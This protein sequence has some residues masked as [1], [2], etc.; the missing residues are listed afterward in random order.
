MIRDKHTV[1]QVRYE[2]MAH[3]NNRKVRGLLYQVLTVALVALIAWWLV[4]TTA[5]NLARSNTVSGYG[6]LK[7]RAGFEIG[8]TLIP[9]SGDSTYGRALFV[10]FL[11][12]LLIALT[13]IA[14]ATILGFIVAIGRQ[15]SNWLVCR[16]SALYVEVFRNTPVLLVIFLWY[17]GVLSLLPQPADSIELPLGILINNRGMAVPSLLWE[18]EGWFVFA[19]LLLALTISIALRFWCK[20]RQ[21]LTGQQFPLGKISALLFLV[22]PTVVFFVT[23]APVSF[24]FPVATRF[25]VSGGSTLAPEFVALYLALSIYTAAFIAEI[26]RAGLSGVPSGQSEAATALGIR[27]T[28]TRRLIVLPQALRIII[29]PLTSQYLNL[30]KNSSLGLAIGFPELVSTGGTVMNQ[31]GQAMEIVSIWLVIFLTTSIFTSACMNLINHK[32]ALLER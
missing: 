12:T 28:V 32:A 11:N 19:A 22:L 9:Y 2:V 18:A 1:A 20:R 14:T 6:F 16:L 7:G 10:G 15:S 31:T 24:D 3:L 29:P 23:D 17:A 5:T 4:S 26:I 21:A 27:P 13:G 8:Q 30:T 25:N